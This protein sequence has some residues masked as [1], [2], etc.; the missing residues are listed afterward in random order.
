MM[1]LAGTAGTVKMVVVLVFAR[2]RQC[3]KHAVLSADVTALVTL[4]SV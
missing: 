2:H 3:S 4:M 1:V